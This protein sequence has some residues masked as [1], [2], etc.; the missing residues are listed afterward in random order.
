MEKLYE[1]T[2]SGRLRRGGGRHP[3][4]PQRP[5]P[6]RRATAADPF[7]REPVVPG[8]AGADPGLSEGGGVATQ[9]LLRTIS[10]VAGAEIVHDAVAFF[11]AFQ[12]MEEGFRDRASRGAR[13]CWPTRDGLRARDLPPPRRRRRSRP[14]SPTS[15]PSVQSRRPR[16]VVNRVHPRFAAVPGSRPCRRLPAGSDL[17]AI[18]RQPARAWTAMAE[19]R[20]GGLRRT[21]RQ[22]RAGSG[23]PG[24]APRLRRPRPRAR[25]SADHLFVR[26]RHAW[27]LESSGY[28]PCAPSWSPATPRPSAR[29]SHR[30]P[31]APS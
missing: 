20:G 4:D 23:R 7:P 22:G 15:W 1:L 30:S 24:P 13:A 28:S 12:G 19:P 31:R 9:A 29:R 25:P 17:A 2:E 26:L 5:R 27:G 10:K 14:S 6:A 21:G 16:S 18:D 3:A 8:P 11:Q